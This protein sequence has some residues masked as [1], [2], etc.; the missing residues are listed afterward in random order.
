M[1]KLWI[2]VLMLWK[3]RVIWKTLSMVKNDLKTRQSI[4]TNLLYRRL[5]L[6]LYS[7]CIQEWC[8]QQGYGTRFEACFRE[9]SKGNHEGLFHWTY[10]YIRQP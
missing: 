7:R 3:R 1:L 4:H 10:I 5:Y 8:R 2:D 6:C 9:Q